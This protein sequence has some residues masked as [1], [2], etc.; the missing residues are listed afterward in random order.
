[1]EKHRNVNEKNDQ[2]DLLRLERDVAVSAKKAA[3]KKVKDVNAAIAAQKVAN[4]STS[5]RRRPPYHAESSSSA[6]GK[7]TPSVTVSMYYIYLIG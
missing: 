5:S 3:E 4:G 2:M 1:M 6:S 7:K